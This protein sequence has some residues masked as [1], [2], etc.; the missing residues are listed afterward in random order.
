MVFVVALATGRSL[1]LPGDTAIAGGT[2]EI[3]G[4]F[5][6][7]RDPQV[8]MGFNTTM[9]GPQDSQVGANNSNNYGLWYANNYCYGGE[10]K[11]TFTSLG[12]S[13]L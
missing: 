10:S 5:L 9:W 1:K 2:W 11:P 8:S 7:M 4:G 12:G 6:K 13:T 3:Y